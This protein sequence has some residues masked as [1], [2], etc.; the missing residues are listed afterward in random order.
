MI[1]EERRQKRE[2]SAGLRVVS[3][4]ESKGSMNGDRRSRYRQVVGVEDEDKRT[5]LQSCAVACCKGS[6]RGAS[7][8]AELKQAG[9][10]GCLIMRIAGAM[11]LL[12]FVN[13]EDQRLVLDRSDLDRWFVR[14]EAWQPELQI[15]NR[16]VWLSVVGLPMH[17]WSEGTFN[18]I[19]RLWGKLVRVEAA[20]TKPRSFV[21]A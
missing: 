18:S 1:S 2:G 6:L 11:F 7:L 14:V 19:V 13:E 10:L 8:V 21:R 4:S 3:K 17:L 15:E 12:M 5:V 16:S 9:F 20:T